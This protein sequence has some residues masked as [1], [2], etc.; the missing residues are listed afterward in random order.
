MLADQRTR[1]V[2]HHEW[3][4][5]SPAHESD[6]NAALI[7]A[8]GRHAFQ[9]GHRGLSD[10]EF[11]CD[12]DDT[13]VIGYAVEGEP[14]PVHR[15]CTA[16]CDDVERD[17]DEWERRALAAEAKVARVAALAE[18]WAQTQHIA[19]RWAAPESPGEVHIRPV[20]EAAE[21]LLAALAGDEAADR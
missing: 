1:T 11:R 21:L 13:I 15:E 7:D 19:L 18:T 3:I 6:V 2:T 9:E 17:R 4:L 5:H 14:A 10:V 12:G 20:H 16:D 8:R